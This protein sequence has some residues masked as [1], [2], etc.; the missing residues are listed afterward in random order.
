MSRQ[1]WFISDW[2]E[3]VALCLALDKL[4]PLERDTLTIL[5]CPS[6]TQP[7]MDMARIVYMRIEPAS[8]RERG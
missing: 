7:R 4:T 1:L 2:L 8:P 6:P 5:Q 3:P